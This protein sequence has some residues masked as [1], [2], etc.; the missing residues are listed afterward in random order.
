MQHFLILI[1]IEE[2]LILVNDGS[3]CWIE[4][5]GAS[6]G[7]FL[8]TS[9]HL[10]AVLHEAGED[11]CQLDL[12]SFLRFIIGQLLRNEFMIERFVKEHERLLLIELGKILQC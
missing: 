1:L 11:L 10:E 4:Q 6:L 5:D 7:L 8:I 3:M 2:L 9:S 12:R